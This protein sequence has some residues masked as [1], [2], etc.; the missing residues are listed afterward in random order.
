MESVAFIMLEG[1]WQYF[2][3]SELQLNLGNIAKELSQ[4]RFR[5]CLENQATFFYRKLRKLKNQ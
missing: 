4:I 2:Q 3:Q 1:T 5:D